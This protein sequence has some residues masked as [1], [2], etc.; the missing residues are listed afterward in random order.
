MRR[1]A[2]WY[3]ALVAALLG[4]WLLAGTHPLLAQP[5]TPIEQHL[6]RMTV[7]EKV[8]QLFM[9]AFV[10][11]D[12]RPDSDIAQLIQIYKIGGVVLLAI[13]S[14]FYNTENT[15][16]Q[17]ARLTNDLQE[18]ALSDTGPGIP[19]FV[20]IDHEGDGSPYTRLR[21]GFTPLPSAMAIGATWN[22]MNAERVGEIVGRELAAA[23]V[24]ML[25]GPVVDVLN[26]PR[27]SSRGDM[28]VRVFGGDPYWVGEMGRAYIR[29]VHQGSQRRVLTVAKHFP[30]HGGSDRLPDDEIAT[31]DK[32]FQELQRIELPPFFSVTH[33][34]EIDPIA[35]TDALMTSH[36][37]YR[38]FQGDIRQ[39]TPPISFDPAGMR[40]LLALPE[41]AEWRDTGLIVSDALGVSAVR[42]YFD[43]QERTFPAKQIA[44]EAF[45]AGN[46]VLILSQ[47]D[48]RGSWADQMANIKATI[49]FFV[50][51][52]R[53]NP[54]FRQRVDEAVAKILHAKARFYGDFTPITAKVPTDQLDATLNTE[55]SRE[56]VA[57]I[58]QEA[59][60]LIYPRPEVLRE[61]LPTGP[62]RE[63][64]VLIVTDDQL[65]RDC[66]QDIP[67]CAP[68]PVL[69]PS[70]IANAMIRLYGPEEGAGQLSPEQ[71]HTL[72]FSQL[73]S[74]L[75][76]PLTA[77]NGT[78]T[79]VPEA[80]PAPTPTLT[81]T[82]TPVP[83]YI[84][85]PQADVGALLFEADW[86]IF[87]MLDMN[88]QR[89]EAAD[90]VRVF[91]DLGPRSYDK[92]VV[93][94]AL[95]AP[96]HLDTTEI[97]KLS[98]YYSAYSKTPA[99]IYATLRALFGDLTPTGASPVDI[100]GIGYNLTERLAPDPNR[101]IPLFVLK[102]E[103][104]NQVTEFPTMI[105]VQTGR[106]LD[107]NG[108]IVPDG[109]QVTFWFERHDSELLGQV[110]ANTV[111]GRAEAEYKIAMGGPVYVRATSVQASSGRPYRVD[112]RP[113]TPT[114]TPT[115]TATQAPTR[116]PTVAFPTSMPTP[117][118]VAHGSSAPPSQSETSPGG[119][120]LAL[121]LL[122]V[123]MAGG[124]STLVAQANE[125]EP[126][127]Q[128]RLA[129][130]ATVSGLTGYVMYS[131]GWLGAVI[132]VQGSPWLAGIIAL[133][134]AIAPVAWSVVR[135]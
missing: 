90:A 83:D 58:A 93:A 91:L 105:Q 74:F 38:G 32:S 25:L 70:A 75:T 85:N 134:F 5:K 24:N 95:N 129:L 104:P 115:S 22:P 67:E 47:F 123:V 28:G 101:D 126:A 130:F 14:N 55:A 69:N 66:L 45:L 35:T 46:D 119:A 59:I 7:E 54:S 19:L 57:E 124:L 20:A 102:P 12:T 77:S 98:A 15:P 128:V 61:R 121:T 29:G 82:L 109:T 97:S 107:H 13:N 56:V 30:G 16:Q 111:D 88:T 135:R 81:P 39:F 63:D 34:D 11:Q 68:R 76:T 100:E 73:R 9:V 2:L 71:I 60:T 84:P 21:S 44:K 8:G 114:P 110:T 33:I 133:V 108:N 79:P 18:L 27:L 1:Q 78:A 89:F 23:G 72:T 10:G 86:I 64:T 3:W 116:T 40:Q 113:P 43:P 51:E 62:R 118:S 37:R 6:S 26:N 96:Y 106:V 17:V 94:I 36:I 103:S 41:F 117:L 122:A 50:S 31:V 112:F 53:A 92:R 132:A 52:Y 4:S 127:R 42:R 99:F 87:A 125:V 131:S 65:G 49:D 80:M 120:G 48:L